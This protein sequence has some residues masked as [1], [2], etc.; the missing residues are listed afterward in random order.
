MRANGA[1]PTED[2]LQRRYIELMNPSMSRKQIEEEL[3]QARA[4]GRW[5]SD[6]E[7][8]ELAAQKQGER[9]ALERD[10]R[11]R[12]RLVVLTGVFLLIPPMWP[13]AA[14]LAVYLLFPQSFRRLMLSAGGSF[15]VF[16]ALGVGT[17][18][19]ALALLWAV[20]S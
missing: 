1:A 4:M 13:V 19:V 20:L 2:C 7:R 16:V 18:G 10:Q 17:V 11:L 8:E 3:E 9:L 15:L 6:E 5:L 12:T 14:G